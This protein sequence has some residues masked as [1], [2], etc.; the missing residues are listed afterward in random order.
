MNALIKDKIKGVI[1]G[2]A[3][4]DALGLGTEFLT[5][6][7]IS[8]Y[9][10]N[11]LHHYDQ[12]VQDEHRTRWKKGSW[13]DDTAQFLCILESILE[14]NCVD[15]LDIA[16]RLQQWLLID[17]LGVGQTTA[18]VLQLP[19]YHL[20]PEK[21]AELVWKSRGK[22][23]AA[24]GGLMRNSIVCVFNYWDTD[25][26]LEN[27]ASI[28]KLTHFDPRCSDSCQIMA[29][30]ILGEL[31]EQ[32]VDWN[33]FQ[34]HLVNYDDRIISYLKNLNGNLASLHLDDSETMG[35]TLKGLSAGA[36][37]YYNSTT[38]E[39][40]LLSIIHEGGDADTNGA[41]AGSILG[42]KYGYSSIP[43]KWITGLIDKTKL[44]QLTTAF[45]AVL[46]KNYNKIF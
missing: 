41:I 44:E 22:K 42:A 2:Q 6:K 46:E 4:G 1:F 14:N 43:E 24:N 38:F 37:A 32:P 26:V 31:L 15:C 23:I 29:L 39:E 45:I 7:E 34:E 21:A 9:Y 17:G 28:C 5:K 12:I 36:W 18:Q 35:Y 19:Q 25:L 8:K 33:S 10:P 16:K 11:G 40:T 30:L 3:I 27:T 13:T 20:F